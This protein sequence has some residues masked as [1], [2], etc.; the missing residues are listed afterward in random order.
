MPRGRPSAAVSGFL[1]SAVSESTRVGVS[2]PSATNAEF[3][4]VPPACRPHH[5]EGDIANVCDLS[6]VSPCRFCG[7]YRFPCEPPCFCCGCGKI[8]LSSPITPAALLELFTN[9]LSPLAISFRRKIRLY[10]TIFSFTSFGVKLD[11][12]LASLRHGVY[13]FRASGQIFH[14]LPPL[15]P[16]SDGPR[17]FQLYFWDRDNELDNRMSA[18]P[19]ADVD[20]EIMVLLMDIMRVN[21][22]AQ[23]LQ[24]IN[25]YSS[26][27]DLRL[28]ISKN[29][30]LDQRCYNNPSADQVAAIWVE[31]NDD[32]NIPY[33]RDIVA[34][35]RD[36]QTHQIRHYYGCYDPLQYPLFFPYGENGWQQNILKVKNGSAPDDL[37]GN[38]R[39]PANIDSFDRIV[40]G[41][42]RVVRGRNDRMVSCREY[43]CYR[44][45]IR[46]TNT[47]VILYGGRLL[48]QYVVD[49]YV[50]LETTRLDYYRRH[51]S[52]IRS[53]MYQGVVESVAN[54]ESRGSEVGQRIVL[55]ASFIGGPR[56][57]RR[58]Y[59]DAI[60]LVRKFGK[61]D[62]FITMTCNPDW[63]EIREHLFQGQ[64]AHD[65]PDLV[66]RVFRAKL[67]DLKDQ[68][69]KKSIFGPV[70]AYVYV[71]E[72]QKRG[73]P[74]CHMLLILQSNY[75]I[76]SPDKFDSYV[77]A[78]LPD[79]NFSPRLF[80]LVS[81]HMMH[82]PCGELNKKCPCM[83]NGKCKNHYPRPF[84]EHSVQHSNGYPLYRRRDNGRSVEVRNCTLNSQW[85]VP[86]NPYLLFRYDCH[87][88]VE[89]CS[90]LTAVKYLYKYI[91]KGHDKISIHLSTHDSHSFV[92]EI[93]TFQDAHW[94]SPPEA[95]WRIFEFDLNEISPAVINLPLH[96]PDRHMVT[97]LNYQNLGNVLETDRVSKTMLTEFFK[98]C[99]QNSEATE[100]LYSEFPEHYVWNQST[101]TWK[102]RKQRQVIGRVN[103]ANPVEG[104]R[105]YLRLLL[106]HVRG[107]KSYCDLLTIGEKL[108]FTFKEAAQLR[109][110]L[111]SD[112]SN[113]ECLNEASSFHMPI[114]L[115]RLFATIL[116]HCEPFDVRNLWDMFYV[117]LSEDFQN[118][119]MLENDQVLF[120]T[121]QSIR[122]FLES[123]GKTSDAY[124][125][126]RLPNSSAKSMPPDCREITDEL[127]ISISPDDLVAHLQ[128]NDNQR[129][130]YNMIIESLE[131][132]NGAV[133]F[134]NGP[135]GTGKT[136]LYRSLLATIR[137]QGLIALAT[138]TSGV[139]AS[140]LPGGRTAHSRFKIPIDL[141]ANSYCSISKQSGLAQLLRRAAVI[142]WD[143]APM[144]KR[145]AIEAVDRTLQDLVGNKNPFG[146][147]VVVLGGDFMQI[148][149][150]IPKATMHQ[151][152][153]S[154]LIKSHLYRCMKIVVL[155][156][157]M[158]ARSD[159][160]FCEFLL[161]VG[162]GIEQT[163]DN[164]NIKLPAEMLIKFSDNDTEESERKLLDYVY[165]DLGNNYQSPTYMTERTILS[166]KNVH[167]DKLNDDIVSL[168]PG[169]SRV[170]LSFDEAIDDTQ[171]S[172]PSEFLNSLA[173]NGLP[174]HRLV[175]KKH[176]PVMLL[177]NLDPSDG[178]CN[179]TRMICKDFTDNVI[180]AEIAVGHHTGKKVL[181]PRIPLSPAENEGYPFRFKRKQFPIKLCFAMTINKSQGQTIPI[182]G[183]YLPDPVFSHGQ[184]YVAMSRGVSMKF[185]RFLIKPD[186][187]NSYDTSLTKNV[188][189]KEV[190]EGFV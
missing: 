153:D 127:S 170:Y 178:L 168:F 65:R 40:A 106:L 161:R 21:P 174:P 18:F 173:P 149:P 175:L 100:L 71:I 101:R 26:I 19:N 139:A 160:L 23:I 166:T 85:V 138:A 122:Y 27:T 61:P 119:M 121:L 80:G 8:R 53:E 103:S 44:L 113:F 189:Y 30:S 94:V 132:R 90:G 81:R 181:I 69:L 48:Q 136:F 51:Q 151:T 34:R 165:E 176:C 148:L 167:V 6:L 38:L 112:K 86:Y 33:D 137:S 47:S 91:Y 188:V 49:M 75:K 13:T 156:E 16:D 134:I 67:Q 117:H 180:H 140:I 92:D 9:Q 145:F 123:M 183:V 125:L 57:M 3:G 124:D 1:T 150:V 25:Q 59:L 12:E 169:N 141:H 187:S 172:Y 158:R 129:L 74:H 46:L 45:Q 128:L 177:R 104:E 37:N 105:Y 2:F 54:G 162:K 7:A 108:C 147:K 146:G 24:R 60:A 41:E 95:V 11:K 126:P 164:G 109:G 179:G 76:T 52:E 96:L 15:L 66:S 133:F 87:I 73:L 84:S 64:V 97:F 154:C 63:K 20:R 31:G 184:L 68:I 39:Q 130:A 62:L 155:S 17:Y 77:V 42:S 10:N 55:P 35:A 5:N 110:L 131:T 50:K 82:G 152:I 78:E 120:E 72:F 83:V 114:A 99:S 163:D 185:I 182:I 32:T 171:N 115:R 79:K 135:G 93:R 107:P 102:P 22:Y 4:S 143:E 14:S 144:C 118:N 58:R 29:V 159:P 98:T 56:D 116:V 28:H 36:G 89:I 190:L 157:N 186:V 111:E 142:I 43:Y 70:V 88:N